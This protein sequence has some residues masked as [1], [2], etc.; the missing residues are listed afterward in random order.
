M[1][2]ERTVTHQ[3]CL[4]AKWMQEVFKLPNSQITAM[5]IVSVVYV[6]RVH[7][8]CLLFWGRQIKIL[9]IPKGCTNSMAKLKMRRKR[10]I[11]THHNP[12]ALPENLLA[13]HGR[14]QKS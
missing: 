14:R 3:C 4:K 12:V 1:L 5:S 7:S 9:K 13:M 11:L 6:T 2:P 8:E 10:Q